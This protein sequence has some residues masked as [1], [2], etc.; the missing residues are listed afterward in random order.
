LL[1]TGTVHLIDKT[2]DPFIYMKKTLLILLLLVNTGLF[3]QH[4]LFHLYKDSASL[5][6]EANE[7][8]AS[9]YAKV[10][11]ADASFIMAPKVILNTQPSLDFYQAENNTINLPIWSQVLPS[12][13]PF[14]Y[15]LA[16]G[17]EA[18]GKKIFGLFFN[19]FYI[20]HELGHA[21]QFEKERGKNNKY[22]GEY[23]AN[24]LAILF[25]R[26]SSYKKELD[27][28]YTYINKMLK[29]LPDPVPAGENEE[30][31]FN[32]N[33][34]KLSGEPDQY[35]YFQF[36]QFRKIYEDKS[37]TSFDT[38]LKNYSSR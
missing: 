33:F 37:L 21:V 26:E 11:Q 2:P 19:G 18:E 23:F 27:N 10:K 12:L 16:G 29:V 32:K 22:Q 13:K 7:I 20:A 38:F 24:T 14:F 34:E 15:K 4:K 36:S 31:Y 28:C 8:V 17:K 9:F 30:D 3:A 35:G 1:Y 5:V 6:T 25:W